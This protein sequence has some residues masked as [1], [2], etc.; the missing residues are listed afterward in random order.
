MTILTERMVD[1]M[2]SLKPKKK[3]VPSN[4]F[5]RI[6]K[7]QKNHHRATQSVKKHQKV[8]ESKH[9]I[10]DYFDCPLVPNPAVEIKAFIKPQSAAD[11]GI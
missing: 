5:D 9:Q 4:N 10:P 6:K 3:S 7:E 1:N 11:M 2:S 8:K